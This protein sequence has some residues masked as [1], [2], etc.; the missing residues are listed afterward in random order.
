[1]KRYAFK[2]V[3]KTTGPI[4]TKL[5]H[6]E[7]L[8]LFNGN[9]MMEDAVKKSGVNETIEGMTIRDETRKVTE[10]MGWEEKA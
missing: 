7:L 6:F 1:M 2:L 9:N 3:F 5:L 8:E 4:N 10:N